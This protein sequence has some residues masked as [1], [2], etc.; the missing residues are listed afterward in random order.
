MGI[1]FGGLNVYYKPKAFCNLYK[2]LGYGL[3]SDPSTK[4]A[5]DEFDISPDMRTSTS[6]GSDMTEEFNPQ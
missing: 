2:F 5:V 1:I 3:R 6:V 4:T